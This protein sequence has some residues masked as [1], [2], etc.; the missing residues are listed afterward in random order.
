MSIDITA[1][2]DA[3][4]FTLMN[5]KD[6]W[7]SEDIG[8][9][10]INGQVA[11]QSKGPANES[12]QSL[13]LQMTN[14]NPALFSEQ[15][16]L[17]AAGNLRFTPLTNVS[18]L[19]TLS[20]QLFDDGG[21]ANGGDDSSAIQ[22]FTITVEAVNDSP[23]AEDDLLTMD[24]D[25]NLS[26]SVKSDNGN[27]ADSDPDS[28]SDNFTYTL[29]DGGSAIL[30]GNLV[31]NADG[32]FTYDP[33]ADF[34]GDVTFTY[35]VCDD[36]VSPLSQECDE[37]TVTITVDQVSDDPL[38]VN[39]DYFMKE[40]DVLNGNV[41]DNDERL[42]DVPVLIVANTNPVSSTLIL[43]SD[44]TFVYT[45]DKGYHGTV[46]FTYTLRDV[47]GSESTAIVTIIVDPLD[48]P[49][50]ANDDFVE[51]DE[52]LAV[53]GDLFANDEDFINPPVL[54]I[55][56]TDP[57]NGTLVVN[58]DGTFTYT[59]NTDFYGTDTF[60][61]TIKDVDGDQDTGLVTITVNPVNDTPIAV[62]DVNTTDEDAGVSGNLMTN[63]TDLGDAEVNVVAN[64]NP[65]NGTVLV[66][67]DGS[68]TYIP[69][70]NFNGVDTFTYTIEDEDGE[71]STAT[72]TIT[73]NSVNDVPVAVDD[74]NSTDEDTVVLGNV[75]TN[76]TDLD[77]DELTVVELNGSNSIL[78]TDII[79]SGGGILR[80]NA[81]GFYEFDPNGEYDY[82]NEGEE[83]QES[84]TYVV[85]D[86]TAN[87]NV[88]T[89][90][91]TIVGV[92]DAP[93]AI[94]DQE[95]ARDNEEIIISVL[96]NDSD[97]DEDDLTV[98]IVTEP[99]FGFVVVNGD[100]TVSYLADLGAYCNTDQFTYR[101]CD[102]SGLCDEAVVTI[103]IDVMDSDEDSI[104]DAIETL[105]ADTDSD[106]TFDYLDLDSD[107]DGISDEDEARISD[108][109]TDFPVDTDGDGTPD[110]LDSDSDNDGY[111]D[112]EEGDDDCDGDGILDYMDPYDDCAE[113]VSIPEGFSPNGD[114]VN[115]RL[116]I[117]GMKDF[118]NSELMIF[119]RW[120]AKIYSK[121]GYQNDWDGRADNSMTVGTNVIPEGTYYYVIDLGN[122][123]KVIKG[124]I[125][126]NY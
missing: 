49:P 88:A 96:D 41:F 116:V 10:I 60:K 110:Y 73:V 105:T 125:Y 37:A 29:T 61:Y 4:F 87:S 98:T 82:L 22:I 21:T 17:D 28:D 56:N 39:D 78:G 8:L 35:Q 91:I 47:D 121:K 75:L 62:A 30:N 84:F 23:V 89:V 46:S 20:V 63:D 52:E 126:I 107:N 1:V 94:D 100:G 24:E 15:P 18:G 64:T 119:N 69:N 95:I 70:D 77:D 83:V 33:N 97:A 92:N 53:S 48:Y 93:V 102:P 106:G 59:P 55:S 66:Q 68:Y 86:G 58:T 40:D 117:K 90:I 65:A 72:V 109:C 112:E 81:D 113:Y 118:P 27:G 16:T 32:T 124:F 2:N 12:A 7:V 85:T 57:A 44:G 120:G 71:Q 80:L 3:P 9:V 5:P 38:A 31:L 6:I 42:V 101:I 36:A 104:P 25:T 11:T 67:P 99:E 14:D 26:G 51:T 43:N 50:I 45:P 122:G 79:M 19:A 103:E 108:S 34:F 54:V 123:S 13:N 114:G 111:Q 76:D 74:V 115:D